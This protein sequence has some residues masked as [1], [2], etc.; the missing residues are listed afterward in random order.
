[1]FAPPAIMSGLVGLIAIDTSFGL[2]A[3]VVDILMFWNCGNNGI[4]KTINKSNI[5]HGFMIFKLSLS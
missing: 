1:M 4:E 3:F 2:D 5:L